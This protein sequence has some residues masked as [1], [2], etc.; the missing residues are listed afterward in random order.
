MIG[1]FHARHI[2]HCLRSKAAKDLKANDAYAAVALQR[3]RLGRECERIIQ[4]I[5]QHDGEAEP[6]EIAQA[7]G[8]V[9]PL[10][11]FGLSLNRAA[12]DWLNK[13]YAGSD[14]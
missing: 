6:H 7:L 2:L 3:L 8:W 5:R 13:R 9:P 10:T 12:Q 1:E 4:L 14:Q 11:L